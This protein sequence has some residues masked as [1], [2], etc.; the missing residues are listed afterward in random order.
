M[1]LG[2]FPQLIAGIVDSF[3]S[4]LE[5]NYRRHKIIF[6]AFFVITHILFLELFL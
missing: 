4:V 2:K 3:K 6:C 5:I 1:N